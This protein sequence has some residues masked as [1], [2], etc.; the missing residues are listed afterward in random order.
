MAEYQYRITV[1]G[2]ERTS[3]YYPDEQWNKIFEQSEFRGGIT[4][5]LE[6][7]LITTPVI[8]K[9][10]ED[11]EQKGYIQIDNNTVVCPWEV[12]AEI[13]SI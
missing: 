13:E 2:S 8:L 5:K 11:A 7:R 4:A 1:N 12:L 3:D 10:V 9:M 6:R